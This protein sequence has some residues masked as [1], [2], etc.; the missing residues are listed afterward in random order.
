MAVVIF[1]NVLLHCLSHS[2][3]EIEQICMTVVFIVGSMALFVGVLFFP[4]TNRS[5]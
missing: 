1:S 2:C 3:V 4:S 5:K